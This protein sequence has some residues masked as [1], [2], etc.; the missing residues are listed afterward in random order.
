MTEP[1]AVN[2]AEHARLCGV[3][4]QHAALINQL[5]GEL[6]TLRQ[7]VQDVAALRREVAELRRENADLRAAVA[8]ATSRPPAA[9][10]A[11]PPPPP[12]DVF[13]ALPDKWDGTDGR[14]NVFLTALDL[15]FEF[16]ATK[17]STDRLRIALLVSLLS[18]QAAEWATAVLRADTDTAHS[19]NEFTSQLRLTFEHPAGEVE[20]DTKLYHLR[21]GGLSVSRYTAEFR[22]LAVQTAWGDAALRTSYYEGLAS[23]IKDELAGRELPAT[24]EGL[25]QLALRIDQRLLSRPKPAPRTL[26]PAPIHAYTSPRPST[27]FTPAI[28]EPVGSPPP[29]VVNTG[30]GEP[31]QLRRASLT[32]TERERRF[33]EDVSAVPQLDRNQLIAE[34]ENDLALQQEDLAKSKKLLPKVSHAYKKQA[35]LK[36]F[37]ALK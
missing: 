25:I 18:G 2:P 24:L 26:P 6:A 16:N 27:T 14:C 1:T 29:A 4:D 21:Q 31:M 33:R 17:Y 32:V 35:D 28:T 30:A 36:H 15:V 37:Q 22:T 19:Y 11:A 13:L 10:A 34:Q 7:S 23:R 12:S 5:T 9:A 20:T 3:V 8:D